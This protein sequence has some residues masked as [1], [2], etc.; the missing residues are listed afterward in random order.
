[1]GK[2][3]MDVSLLATEGAVVSHMLWGLSWS[4]MK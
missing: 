2:A 3:P 1:M 4:A